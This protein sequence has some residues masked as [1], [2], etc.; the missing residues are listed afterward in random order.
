MI[1]FSILSVVNNNEDLV[2]KWP[3]KFKRKALK[4]KRKPNFGLVAKTAFNQV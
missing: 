3:P 4:I 1:R 2:L